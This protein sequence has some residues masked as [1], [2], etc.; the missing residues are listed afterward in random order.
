M[1]PSAPEGIR[2]L[3]LSQGIAGPYCTKLLADFGATVVKV[4]PPGG[5]PARRAGPF[6]DDVPHPE[7]SG[8]FLYLNT[9]KKGV[10]LD[11]ETAT[12]ASVLKSL[13]GKADVVV[14]S[15]LPGY[16]D[17]RGLGYATLAAFNPGLVMT[18]VTYFGQDGPYRDWQGCDLIVWAL[19]GLMY[20][21]G[22]AGREPLKAGGTQA[23]FIAG[24]HAAVATMGAIYLGEVSGQGQH[25]D[26]S[27]VESVASLTEGAALTYGYSG[28][29]RG[30]DGAR[31]HYAYP[32]TILPC[33]DGYIFVHG[34]GDW[35][36]FCTFLEAPALRDPKYAGARG[37]ADEIDALML[38]FLQRHTAE[39][40]FHS[41][42]LWR[43][44]LSLVQDIGEVMNDPQYRER[45]FFVDISHPEAGRLTYPGAPFRMS[46]SPW[47]GGRAPMLGEHNGEVYGEWL[48]L[49]A[50]DLVRLR[51]SGAI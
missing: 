47:C 50:E 10:T 40:L 11:L 21:T 33:K 8:L 41:A 44:P 51:Q 20:M 26:V 46:A 1:P 13:V 35:D 37:L 22:E 7:K 36:A 14:E 29:V 15:F 31:H 4:E 48:G 28:H 42:Q 43:I 30:R 12:G 27:A 2:V 49:E 18:S 39:E 45:G 9:N 32:S 38:P 23:E 34:G 6:P 25:L 5:D 17:S 19:G 3:D 24:L 16:L